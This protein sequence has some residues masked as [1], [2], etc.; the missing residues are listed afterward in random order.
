MTNSYI[1]NA[2]REVKGLLFILMGLFLFLAFFSF[3]PSDPSLS[4]LGSMDNVQN[5]AGVVGAFIADLSFQTL[6]Y[7]AWAAALFLL[8]FG[9]QTLV[10]KDEETRKYAFLASVFRILALCPLVQLLSV[11]TSFLTQEHFQSG[12]LLGYFL[13]GVFK[14]FFSFWGSIF[15]FICVLSLAHYKVFKFLFNPDVILY[16]QASMWVR[17]VAYSAFSWFA[18]LGTSLF[19]LLLWPF[20]FLI[21]KIKIKFKSIVDPQESPVPYPAKQRP[22]NDVK[23][24]VAQKFDFLSGVESVLKKN[25]KTRSPQGNQKE[26]T[27]NEFD[28]LTK[29]S[30]STLSKAKRKTKKHFS[31]GKE[32]GEW[33]LP[34]V[35]FLGDESTVPKTKV[36]QDDIRMQAELLLQKLSEFKIGGHIINSC[37]GPAVTLFEFRPEAGIPVNRIV[38]HSDD[39]ALALSSES[40]RIIAPIPGRDVVGIEVAN[41]S[42]E[43]VHLADVLRSPDFWKDDIKIPIPLGKNISGEISIE[44]L[45]T[46]PH[47]MVAGSTG[48]GKSVFTTSLLTSFIYKFSPEDMKLVLIDP[49]QVDLSVFAKLPHLMFPIIHEPHKAVNV[50]KAAVR[51]MEKRYMSFKKFGV[52]KFEEFNER[53]STLEKSEVEE[54]RE[55]NDNTSDWKEKYYFEPMPYIVIVIEE[56]ADLMTVDKKN[57]ES[58]VVRLAQMARAAGIHLILA[59]QSPRKEVIT[60][61]IK[62]NIAGRISF[63]VSGK[64]D[65]RIIL[66][67][68]GAESLLSKGDML[69]KS[70]KNSKSQRFHG[71]WL[72]DEYIQRSVDFW[73][74]QNKDFE[75]DKYYLDILD[76]LNSNKSSGIQDGGD[77]DSMYDEI[78]AFV[79]T[80]KE[81]SASLIQRHFRIGY[82]RAA[83][84]M[85]Y[86]VQEGVIGDVS[87][88]RGRKVLIDE[89][90]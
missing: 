65:S 3:S 5:L 63:K 89:I 53:V 29:P 66:D 46:M 31:K 67:E 84:L 45:T 7:I 85:D 86:M 47:M 69:M 60:G 59:L 58:L 27:Q 52:R 14:P 35:A 41:K 62:T 74:D 10:K 40:I 19:L 56:F 73:A 68:S 61:L 25:K 32:R 82:P 71:P 44:D 4:S 23:L 16:S 42:R 81:I 49:K 18:K 33:S 9:Y 1:L 77:V 11:E 48:S 13:V 90:R 72:S 22:T 2:Y 15:L 38:N 37:S 26:S 39:L 76:G 87:S 51:E 6:G 8:I 64:M 79:S 21:N 54:H 12:G 55:L 88:S 24:N 30:L 78:L 70:P 50:L 75:F 28:Q 34:Q 20:R 57:V 83:R 80:Q 36:N 43:V 17:G